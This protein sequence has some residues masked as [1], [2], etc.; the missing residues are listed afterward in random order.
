MR[1][2]QKIKSVRV[3]PSDYSVEYKS[4]IDYSGLTDREMQRIYIADVGSEKYKTNTLIHEILHAIFYEQGLT[5]EYKMKDE[6][7]IVL[8]LANGLHQFLRDNPK[9]FET[10]LR[11]IRE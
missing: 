9:Q 8:N 10:I 1:R 4:N 5:N 3:G 6:E 7:R 11:D 2:Q